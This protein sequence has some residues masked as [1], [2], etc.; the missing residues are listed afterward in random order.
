MIVS[1]GAKG[2]DITAEVTAKELGMATD[3]KLPKNRSKGA[4]YARNQEV[5]DACD[6]L[7]AFWNGTSGGTIDTIK[8][9]YRAGKFVIVVINP[10][11]DKAQLKV[12][13]AREGGLAF[14]ERVKRRLQGKAYTD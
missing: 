14:F 2:V 11:T 7:Y 8:R 12:K 4:L 6:E 5:V 3:I 10:N 13:Q 1:G 9:A